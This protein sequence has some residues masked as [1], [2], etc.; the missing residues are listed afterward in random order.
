M[1]VVKSPESVSA[2]VGINITIPD[3]MLKRIDRYA[4]KHGLRWSGFL[5]QAAR[6]L[7]DGRGS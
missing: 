6:T 3:Q 4:A 7:R 5:V 1:L 2:A